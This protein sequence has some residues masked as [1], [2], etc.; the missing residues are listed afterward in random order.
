[1]PSSICVWM[2][3]ELVIG[4]ILSVLLVILWLLV[5]SIM[6][7]QSAT[8]RWSYLLTPGFGDAPSG[9]VAGRSRW[10][11][12][13]FSPPTTSV[14]LWSMGRSGIQIQEECDLSN[15]IVT[16]VAK[17]CRTILSQARMTLCW[18]RI[19]I[20]VRVRV[21]MRVRVRIRVGLGSGLGLGLGFSQIASSPMISLC[22]FCSLLLF[23]S[24]SETLTTCWLHCD[25][26]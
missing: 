1:M 9:T 8:G 3:L 7:L 11:L 2:R 26:H 17:H 10:R 18:V 13:P 16:K 25:F 20:R 6:Y 12:V 23:S 5:C 19:K 24:V 22:V 21:W 4:T 15:R 14:Y